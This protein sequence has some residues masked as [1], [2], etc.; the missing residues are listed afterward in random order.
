MAHAEPFTPACRSCSKIVKGLTMSVPM[1]R[2]S[3][4]NGGRRLSLQDVKSAVAKSTS[5]IGM[6]VFATSPIPPTLMADEPTTSVSSSSGALK[7]THYGLFDWLDNRSVYGKDVF[8]TPLLVDCTDLE[9]NEA[10]LYW[11]HTEGSGQRS[12]EVTAELEKAFGLLTLDLTIPYERDVSGTQVSRG[13]GIV[14]LSGRYPIFQFVS[15]D[16]S[17]D[18]TLGGGVGCGIPGNL[19]VSNNAKFVPR[20]FVFDDL[21]IGNHFTLQSVAGYSTHYGSGADSGSE[22]YDYGL[23]LGY[24]LPHK[25]LPLPDVEQFIPMFELIGETQL[26]KADPGHNSLLG[27]AGF[28]VGLKAIGDFEPWFRL[29]FVFPV[30]KGGREDLHSGVTTSLV[31]DF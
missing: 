10:S 17:I 7:E 28:Q 18:S 25:E 29:G 4:R 14:D 30:D 3:S 2:Q 5:I 27:A 23:A 20:A 16:R 6:C 21:K 31:F 24:T 12:D 1:I 15:D 13:V 26:N 19:A 9:S 11:L 22:T 8:P